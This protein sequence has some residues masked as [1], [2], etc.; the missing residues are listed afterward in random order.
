MNRVLTILIL[1]LLVLCLVSCTEPSLDKSPD[2]SKNNQPPIQTIETTAQPTTATPKPTTTP[3]ASPTAVPTPESTPEQTEDITSDTL[4][5]YSETPDDLVIIAD[6]AGVI[7]YGYAKGEWITH[8][9]ATKYFKKGM[10]F[11]QYSIEGFI[12]SLTAV[13]I[14]E[15]NG[16]YDES[17]LGSDNVDERDYSKHYGIDFEEN[18]EIEIGTII[19]NVPP[20]NV[21][22]TANVKDF[23]ELESRVQ[24]YLNFTFGGNCSQ[25]NIV[26]ATKVDLNGDGKDEIMVSANN[27]INN[28]ADNDKPWYS[29]MFVIKPDNSVH[30]LQEDSYI[31][32]NDYGLSYGIYYSAIDID[33]DGKCEIIMD[34]YSYECFAIYVYSY[35]G[36]YKDLKLHTGA[37]S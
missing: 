33:G 3:M 26:S 5:F 15:N 14:K 7:L 4:E 30:I 27:Y 32:A 13:D 21:P 37:C 11:Y 6:L 17:G 20:E 23:S 1:L 35:N 16:W 28:C 19:T 36:Y 34:E 25:V 8:T 18:L 31:G 29:I 24:S 12:S 2:L 10:V 9:E 22:K